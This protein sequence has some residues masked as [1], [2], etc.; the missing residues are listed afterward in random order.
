MH[1]LFQDREETNRR[2]DMTKREIQVTHI[3][4][5]LGI[6]MHI[7]QLKEGMVGFRYGLH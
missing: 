1:V 4:M 2:D 6:H 7:L 3:H 5:E